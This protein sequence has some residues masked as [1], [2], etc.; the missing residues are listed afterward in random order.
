MIFKLNILCLVFTIETGFASFLKNYA[1]IETVKFHGEA[2]EPLILT[3]LLENN[4]IKEAQSAAK[5]VDPIFL[6][7]TSYSGYFTVSKL[8]N[9]NMFFWFFPSLQDPENAPVLLWLQGGPGSSSMYGL[10]S[11]NGPFEIVSKSQL[12]LRKETWSK[13]HNLLYIDNPV[14]TGFSFTK[15]GYA[16]NETQVGNDL[17]NVLQQFFTMFPKLQKNELYIS[18]ESYA[19]KYI[20]AISHTILQKN[21]ESKLKINLKGVAI[22]NG[23]SDPATQL[24]YGDRLYQLGFIDAK[25]KDTFNLKEKM[26]KY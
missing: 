2:G 24:L 14:G 15:Y 1:R 22:G 20:P 10:F 4:K 3:P 12:K 21:P 26:C 11:E 16:D 8:Y 17:F 7:V 23:L 9:S 25:T 13:E 6:N 5:V 19:G 18:G